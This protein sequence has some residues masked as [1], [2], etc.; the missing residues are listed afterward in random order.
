VK[1]PI[2]SKVSRTKS[3]QTKIK[4]KDSKVKSTKKKIVVEHEYSVSSI[5]RKLN[6]WKN[7][8]P[9]IT[10]KGPERQVV[11]HMTG[12]LSGAFDDVRTESKL[13]KNRIDV[14]IGKIGVEV[15]YRAK[16]NAINR[17]FGQVASYLEYLDNVIVV[18]YDTNQ[19]MVN[20]FKRM[21]KSG[22]F[23]K[24]VTVMTI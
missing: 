17:L 11:R 15:K 10:G 19:G 20:S 3:E 6:Q 18:F 12:Y 16:Q 2:K 1:P 9:K 23:D 14:V 13:G 5:K 8:V 21:L 7:K 22:N 4:E 24:K